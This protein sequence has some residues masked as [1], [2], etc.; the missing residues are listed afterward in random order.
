[1]KSTIVEARGQVAPVAET[2]STTDS[3]KA[4]NVRTMKKA[5]VFIIFCINK[6]IFNYYN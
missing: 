1:V 6:L 4:M 5:D 2:V 3:G